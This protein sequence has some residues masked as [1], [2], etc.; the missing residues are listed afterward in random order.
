MARVGAVRAIEQRPNPTVLH[1]ELGDPVPRVTFSLRS[2]PPIFTVIRAGGSNQDFQFGAVDAQSPVQVALGS[3]RFRPPFPLSATPAT[4]TTDLAIDFSTSGKLAAKGAA[5]TDL[6]MNFDTGGASASAATGGLYASLIEADRPIA[7]WGLDNTPTLDESGHG[8]DLTATG[9]PSS[10]PTLLSHGNEVNGTARDFNGSTDAYYALG[11]LYDPP[12]VPPNFHSATAAASATTDAAITSP[13][14]I[15]AGDLVLACLVNNSPTATISTAPAGWTQVGTTL[16][17]GTCA[18]AVYKRLPVADEPPDEYTW[19]WSAV[20]GITLTTMLVYRNCD[21]AVSG[22][23]FD[24]GQQATTSGGLHSSTTESAPLQSHALAFW[25]TAATGVAII[26]DPTGLKARANISAGNV[27]IVA[28]EYDVAAASNVTKTASTDGN[29]QLGVFLLTFGAPNEVREET[30]DTLSSNLT[31]HALIR[32]DTVA[33]GTRTIIRK[34]QSWG[35]HLNGAT[36]EFVYRDGGGVDRTVTG[37]TVSASTVTHLV[38]ADDGTNIHF[39]KNGVETTS[40][41]LGAAGYTTTTNRVTVGAYHNGT[42]FTNFFDGRLDEVAVFA[43]CVSDQMVAAWYEAHNVGTFGTQLLG[44]QGAGKL[45]RIKV[46]MAFASS[47]TDDTLVWEDVTADVRAAE[48]ISVSRGRN[49]ELDRIE[50]GRLDYTLS[51]RSRQYDDTYT[52]SPYYPNVKPT[53]P[54]RLRAQASTDGRAYPVFFGYTEGHPLIRTEAG[55]D[56]VARFTAIDTFKA[57]ALDKVQG[58]FVRPQE[59]SGTRLQ[60]L[61]DGFPGIPF[62]GDTGQS[63]V[64]GDELV[65]ANS[66]DHAQTVAET[67]GG[68]FFADPAGTMIFQDRHYRAKFSQTVLTTFG[69]GGGV[70]LPV[71]HMEPQ[72][73]EA[74]LFTAAAVTPAS[75]NVKREIDVD[76]ALDHFVRTKEITSIHAVDNDAQAMA[77]AFAHRYATPRTRIPSLTL[78][79]AAHT[80]P[81]TMWATVLAHEI[82]DRVRTVERPIGDTSTV[83]RDHYIEGV[84]HRI[85]GD[86]WVV[87]FS[88]S[89]AELDGEYWRVGTGELG[90]T[91]GSTNTRV[92]W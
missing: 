48:G 53:R 25:A 59:P 67:E 84:S 69:D 75:G 83:T 13:G 20:S 57:L 35:L 47:P 79:P 16:N 9:A 82:S 36:V 40:A 3:R 90:D 42:T 58:S 56:S 14:G 31:L 46:E 72:T 7:W 6:T 71:Q 49:F 26:P 41:R 19:V 62:S 39:Y 81:A 28:A 60:A 34:H 23:V 8:Y 21:Q 24:S 17:A 65:G 18:V 70:E 55:K 92:G 29:T 63:E 68:L 33:A 50:A 54:V 88:V 15:Q 43:A 64:V 2:T 4:I 85:S 61:L 91:T 44:A 27:K 74:R 11:T 73:D 10:A 66:L 32:P 45:P 12:S 89:P 1:P 80:T 86:A 77:E 22:L 76:K 38:V 87:S 30:L 52:L 51:N 78:Q 37:P 5:T